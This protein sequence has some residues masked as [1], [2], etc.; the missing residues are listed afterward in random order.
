M[1]FT[2]AK[3]FGIQPFAVHPENEFLMV[4][5]SAEWV[6]EYLDENWE[7]CALSRKWGD[8]SFFW[9]V[10][11]PVHLEQVYGGFTR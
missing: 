7:L 9:I 4:S 11:L 6:A 1:N 10:G 8:G 3:N 2:S 5:K